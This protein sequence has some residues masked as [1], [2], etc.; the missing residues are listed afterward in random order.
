M[1]P[2]AQWLEQVTHNHLVGGSNPSRPNRIMCRMDNLEDIRE[3]RF[4]KGGHVYILRYR[5]GQEF[6]LPDILI[7]MAFSKQLNFDMFDAA[8]VSYQIGRNMSLPS[9]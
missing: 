3:V 2:V 6:S 4:D 7:E 5:R 1:G 9:Q 8:V